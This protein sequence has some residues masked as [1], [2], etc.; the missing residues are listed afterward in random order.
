V[1]DTQRTLKN[2][3]TYSGI[4]LHTGFEGHVRLVPAPPNSGVRFLRVDLPGRPEVRLCPEN[5]H[6]DAAHARRT[7]LTQDGVEVH[8]V[9]H[10]LSALAGLGLDNLTVELDAMELPEP[11]D[12]SAAPIVRLCL[13]AG[14]EEQNVPR[15]YFRVEKP[16]RL[17]AGA[18]ELLAIPHEG[19][20]ISFTIQ[21]DDEF[22]RTQ[23]A[24]FELTPD[25]FVREI[26]PARTFVLGR[27]IPRLRAQGLIKGGRPGNGIVV[28]D[29]EIEGG[30]SL[31]YPDEFVRHKI[32]DLLGDLYLMGR[33]LLGHFI[34]V[35]SGH[36]FN[37]QF[38]RM[39]AAQGAPASASRNGGRPSTQT[40][41]DI[42]QIMEV[43][44]H[45]YPF[46]LV[47]RILELEAGKRVVGIKNV[48]INEHFFQGHFPGRP[49]MPGVLII[50]A[51]AQCGGFLL[52]N[53]MA[54]PRDKLV[55]FMAIEEA[56]FRRPVAP[57]DTL[58]FEVDM[59]KLKPRMCKV[60]ALAFVGSD[61]VAE[62][63]LLS[64]IVD[65]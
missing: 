40:R 26:A 3:V 47:D 27:D 15:N 32:L 1:K 6:Y 37:V 25:L 56:K 41:F 20:R 46:L 64:G 36:E 43:M 39:L 18:V 33:P 29:R 5:A 2:V 9:E 63:N 58:R 35:R 61:L 59:L 12:G 4:G 13:D 22:V 8:T 54:D 11:Q 23:H 50:E 45:R 62:A 49:V 7:I 48:T 53:T 57:G 52:M 17:V 16:T 10:L 55:Y 38:V 24:S 19:L 14:L 31:R 28:L 65:R 60:R 51:M 34:A 30:G 21:Y 44:P 42:H